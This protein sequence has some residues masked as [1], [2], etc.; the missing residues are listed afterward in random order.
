MADDAEGGRPIRYLFKNVSIRSAIS[1]PMPSTARTGAL[2]VRIRNPSVSTGATKRQ[3]ALVGGRDA[4]LS[5][6]GLGKRFY[7]RCHTLQLRKPGVLAKVVEQ[8]DQVAN[9]GLAVD[10]HGAGG[11]AG[12]VGG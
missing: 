9:A 8:I 5:K 4:V 1:A 11:D 6:V 10:V 12:G 3:A 2:I 7:L